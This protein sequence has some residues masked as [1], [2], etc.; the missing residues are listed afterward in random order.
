MEEVFFLCL[1]I[2]PQTNL[3]LSGGGSCARKDHIGMYR[4][5]AAELQHD[6]GKEKSS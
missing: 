6:E 2:R 4:M 3:N 5:Q 1:K